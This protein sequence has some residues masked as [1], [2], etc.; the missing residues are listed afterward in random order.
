MSE[1]LQQGRESA[2]GDAA[3]ASAQLKAQEHPSGK[4]DSQ[5]ADQDEQYKYHQQMLYPTP[6]QRNYGFSDTFMIHTFKVR[7]RLTLQG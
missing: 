6:G 3:R 7:F 5:P 1:V 4:E 2:A